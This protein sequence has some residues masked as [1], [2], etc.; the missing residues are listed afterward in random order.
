MFQDNA[1]GYNTESPA[2]ENFEI[3]ADAVGRPKGWKAMFEQCVDKTS[4]N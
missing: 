1:V 4:T 2:N 3:L